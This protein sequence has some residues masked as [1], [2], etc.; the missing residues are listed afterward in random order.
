MHG[1][2]DPASMHRDTLPLLGHRLQLNQTHLLVSS[3]EIAADNY[4]LVI[5]ES[6][7]Y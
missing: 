7:Q 1:I 4:N 5:N 3:T 2:I 6:L